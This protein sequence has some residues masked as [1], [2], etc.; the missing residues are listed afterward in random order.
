MQVGCKVLARR[1]GPGIPRRDR[2]KCMALEN[3]RMESQRM[4]SQRMSQMGPGVSAKHRRL[5]KRR[6]LAPAMQRMAPVKRGRLVRSK[7]LALSRGW[8]KRK[9]NTMMVQDDRSGYPGRDL[10]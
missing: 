4:E 10:T 8:V 5:V 6:R 1:K 3:Q 9:E 7:L 2:V